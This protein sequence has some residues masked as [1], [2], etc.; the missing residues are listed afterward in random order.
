MIVVTD[1]ARTVT[2][3]RPTN[4]KQA[5][6][7]VLRTH[8]GSLGSGRWPAGRCGPSPAGGATGS[9]GPPSAGSAATEPRRAIGAPHQAQA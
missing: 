5:S 6:T 7:K 1:H 9:P 2:A 3:A 8:G 4:P